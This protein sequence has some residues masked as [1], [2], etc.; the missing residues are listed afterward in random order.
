MQ[1]YKCSLLLLVCLGA[2]NAEENVS[3]NEAEYMGELD[4]V[5]VISD[6][7][8]Q[9]RS[10]TSTAVSV[11]D[12]QRFDLFQ[13]Q[14]FD[15]V[16][17]FEPGVEFSGGPRVTGEQLE[18]RGQGENAV[19][20][21]ID[22]ARQNFVSGHAGQRFFVDPLLLTSAEIIRGA[23]SQ[24]Y[25]SGSAGVVN[26]RTYEPGD[27]LA[28]HKLFAGKIHAGHQSVNDEQVYSGLFAMGDERL[29][30]LLGFVNRSA[31]DIRLGNGLDLAGSAIDRDSYMAKFHYS[32]SDDQDLTFSYNYY[33]S[34]D[35]NGANPQADTSTSNA[36]VDRELKHQQ[37]TFGYSWD[38]ADDNLIDLDLTAYY[39]RTSQIRAYQA[40]AGSNAGR[41]NEH[42]LETYGLD[43]VNRAYFNAF[44]AE[45]TLIAGVEVVLDRQ[46][47]TESRADFFA[48]GLPGTSSG[49]PDADADSVGVFLENQAKFNTGTTVTAGLRFDYYS[50]DGRNNS[51]SDSQFSP[52]IAIRQEV[53]EGVSIFADYARAF[54]VATLNDLYQSGSHF[55][56]VPTS[57]FPSVTYLEEVFVPNDQLRSESSSNF[58]IGVDVDRKI[59][60]GNLQ[61]KLLGFYKKGKDTIDSEIVDASVTP[62]FFGF[63]GPGALTQLFRQSVNR[64]ETT[65]VGVELDVTYRTELWYARGAYSYTEG[66]DDSNGN[67]LNTIPGDK[68]YLEAGYTP[69][70]NLTVGINALFVGGRDGKVTDTTLQT[71]G[72]S[73][74]GLFANWVIDDSV[75]LT[76]GVDNLFD[77]EY[78]RTNVA[79][80]EAGRNF[81]VSAS[82][83]F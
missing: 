3:E 31:G 51:Q 4:E 33:E 44:G 74:L 20:V 26:L 58:E 76:A 25:G 37:Y 9:K 60:G 52:H 1:K 66:E 62:N 32:P 29:S 57:F 13:S 50:T 61:A 21:R 47:G 38:P 49:R 75:T 69:S 72:Y 40:T 27:L 48:P 14:T 81:Y 73:T 65:I 56:V 46:E 43:F 54:T 7:Y 15:D 45:N 80:T 22:G 23:Q 55:G 82:Y 64:D 41:R 78:E 53:A 28:A 2:A 67:E 42:L 30:F 16:F 24:L 6:R 11:I 8:E 10:N 63:A 39:N 83:A 70:E 35:Q 77:R 5:L 19:T 18:I 59:G 34:N 36:L 17:R 79:N 12:E 68:L 71:S